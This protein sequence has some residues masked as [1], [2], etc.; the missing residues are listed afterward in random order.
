MSWNQLP[1]E[2]FFFWLWKRK[3]WHAPSLRSHSCSQWSWTIFDQSPLTFPFKGRLLRSDQATAPD[4]P[5]TK[6]SPRPISV[7][8]WA[9]AQYGHGIGHTCWWM[10]WIGEVYPSLCSLIFLLIPKLLDWRQ[11][12]GVGNT[13]NRVA[14]LLSLWSV[15]VSA[16]CVCVWGES[17][18]ESLRIL[19][20]FK[21]YMKLLSGGH[22]LAEGLESSAGYN[23]Q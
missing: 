7:R 6:I 15:P 4:N 3:L 10:G 9:K 8:F 17:F 12:L 1:S 11:G 18:V 5:G 22:P 23:T 19:L 13:V 16:G 20:V 2:R 21:I 14:H